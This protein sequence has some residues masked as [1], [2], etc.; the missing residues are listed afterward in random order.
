MEENRVTGVRNT[1]E[2]ALKT[3]VRS[4]FREMPGL[5]LTLPQACRLWQIDPMATAGILED[6]VAEG[7]LR[8][9]SGGA[10]RTVGDR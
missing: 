2:E 3:R 7:F 10:F 8:R 9:T 4:E 1:V 5:L 6:L